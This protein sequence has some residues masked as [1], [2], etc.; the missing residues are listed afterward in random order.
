MKLATA[1]FIFMALGTAAHAQPTSPSRAAAAYK[2]VTGAAPAFRAK[3]FEPSVMRER[4][5]AIDRLAPARSMQSR[6]GGVEIAFFD[7]AVYAIE[8]ER[9]E[10]TSSGGV[11]YSGRISGQPQSSVTIVVNPDAVIVLLSGAGRRFEIV[12]TSETGYVASEKVDRD[13]PDHGSGPD[14]G[15]IEVPLFTS[16]AA[17]GGSEPA[18]AADDGSTLDVAVVY[19]RNT[20]VA[21]GGTS[22]VNAAVDAQI[23]LTNTIYANSDVVQRLRLVYKGEVNYTETDPSSDLT[24]VRNVGDGFLDEVPILRDLYG[25]DFVS[26]WGTGSGYSALCGIGFVMSSENASF[27]TSAY[28]VINSPS[29]TGAGSFTFAHELGHNMGL[30][31]DNFVDSSTTA[32]TPEAGGV[33]A[34]I[35][36][37]HGYIDLLNRFRTVMAYPD[38]CDQQTPAINCTRI[39][40]FSNPGINYFNL[41]YV[42]ATSAPTGDAVLA[43]ERQALNDTRTTTANFR[44]ALDLTGPGTITFLPTQYSVSEGDGTVVLTVGRHAGSS[45]AASVAYA[46]QAGTAQAGSDYTNSSGTLTW[47]SGESGNKTITISLPQDTVLEGTETFTVAL[48]N[49]TGGAGIST[50]GQTATVRILDDES[51]IFPSDNAIPFGYITPNV[52]NANTTDSRWT[53]DTTMGYRSPW[54][55]RSAQ[56][57]SPTATL[58]DY[59][60][61]DLEYTT[62]FTS[63]NA[64]F[65]YRL[66]SYDQGYAGFEF[67]IDGVPVFA[68][69]LGGE[70]DWT[71]VTVPITAGNHQLR[72]RFKNR[73]RFACASAN[74]PAPG[75][76]ACADRV[77]IDNVSLPTG[78]AVLNPAQ[79]PTTVRIRGGH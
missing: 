67:Q 51:D 43:H 56:A 55:L 14:R 58:I 48:S 11:A 24:R 7:D 49:P 15:A 41:S 66:S 54:S 19:T 34:T 2:L 59:G 40:Y 69:N 30:R 6:A 36:Y 79:R 26:L 45:G 31:H 76:G 60:Y 8:I 33:A 1:I 46:A 4:G 21:Y 71:Q 23:A 47:A 9:T 65:Y 17:P 16:K 73:L 10:G 25:A 3:S 38:Q 72:W 5:V 62:T 29:C 18:V 70:V 64:T 52:P 57:R 32:V 39:P 74:P 20:R 27:A 61:S 75:G 53:V 77:W 37:A 44:Q 78:A 12:G 35:T 13:L 42:S 68:N 22:F 50:S 28:N 63:G